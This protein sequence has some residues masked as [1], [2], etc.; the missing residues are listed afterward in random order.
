MV[1]YTGRQKIITGA[2]NRNQVGLKMS[3]CPSRVGRS[4][5]KHT[6]SGTPC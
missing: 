6:S 5:K 4:G 3:G 2:V 1:R